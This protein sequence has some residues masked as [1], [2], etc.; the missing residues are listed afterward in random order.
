MAVVCLYW[1]PH[2]PRLIEFSLLSAFA[3]SWIER[4]SQ[5][6]YSFRK[7]LVEGMVLAGK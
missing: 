2:L 4:G 3:V 6:L 1:F 7:V 5:G